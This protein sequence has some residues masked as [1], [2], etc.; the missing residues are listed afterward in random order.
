M[1]NSARIVAN[2]AIVFACS[3]ICSNAHA[4]DWPRFRGAE[5]AGVSSKAAPTA[6]SDSANLAWKTELPGPGASS[7]IIIGDKIFITCYS[8]YGKS[9]ENPGDIENLKRHLVCVDMKTGD[10]VWQKDV[11]A[12]TPEDKYAGAGIPAHGYASHTPVSD[13]KNIYAFYGKSGV[14]AYDM[15]G[16]ELWQADVGKE[17]DP[18]RW[19]SSS[20]PVLYKDTV[21]VTASAESQSIV[22]IDRNTGKELWRQEAKGLDSMWG[23][24]SLVKVDDDRTDLVMVVANELWGL[25]PENGKMRWFAD[26]KNSRHAY[27]SILHQGKRVYAFTAGGGSVAI[28]ADGTGDI[29]ETNTAWKG[30]DSA[31]FA[32]PVRHEGKIYLVASGILTVVDAE[33]GKRVDRIRLKGMKKTGGRFGTLDYASPIVVGNHLY[34]MNG[35]GQMYVFELGDKTE[36]VSVN[37]VTKDKEI[38]WG[39]P[40]ASDGRIV[41]RSQKY[42][43]CLADKGETVEKDEDS[44]ADAE[45]IDPDEE[46]APRGGRGGRRRFDPDEFFKQADKDEDGSLSMEELEGNRLAAR[47]KP[48]DKDDNK[49]ISKEEFTK[50]I[51]EL[52]RGGGRGRGG[53]EAPKRPDRPQRPAMA[54]SNG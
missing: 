10:K 48:M 38:F 37:Q 35:S 9:Q 28:D 42:L 32:T 24:P 2:L 52:Q 36:L 26:A 3:L 40:S 49:L 31:R 11:N 14:Y 30:R 5:G 21:I 44:D 13:G 23:T 27:T 18:T 7:P 25:D 39:S 34:Y 19:G 15:S 6:W 33:S 20:S 53:A 4:E 50:G 1:T 54:E 47:I 51:A 43:Y 46:A 22:G 41:L 8:G 16:N 17:S 12:V 45:S 29:S